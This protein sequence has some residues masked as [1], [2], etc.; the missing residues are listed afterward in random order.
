M[1]ERA[2]CYICGARVETRAFETVETSSTLNSL[3]VSSP[4]AL[5]NNRR[6]VLC[7]YHMSDIIRV[8][9]TM[10]NTTG[11]IVLDKIVEIPNA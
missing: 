1:A 10:G 11:P 9:E 7:P 6:Y 2:A 8:I 5:I 4:D 3:H